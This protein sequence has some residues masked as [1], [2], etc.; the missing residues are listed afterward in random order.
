MSALRALLSCRAWVWNGLLLFLS[1]SLWPTHSHGQPRPIE[2]IGCSLTFAQFESAGETVRVRYSQMEIFLTAATMF[3]VGAI[4]P[5]NCTTAAPSGTSTTPAVFG[6]FPY[7]PSSSIC[8]AAIHAGII[9]NSAGGSLYVSRFYR[10]DWS[11]T[12]N[13]T[14]Y[15]FEAWRGSLSNGVQSGDVDGSSYRVPAGSREWSYTVRGR[16]DFVSQRRVAPFAPRAG[17]VHELFWQDGNQANSTVST[18]FAVHVIIG[19]NNDTAYFND[20]WVATARLDEAGEDMTWY[21]LEEAPLSPRSD[22]LVV[23]TAPRNLAPPALFL[24]GGQVS[25]AC[26]LYEL[27]V[28]SSEVWQLDV[29]IDVVTGAPSARWSQQTSLS[30]SMASRC[31]SGMAAD[32]YFQQRSVNLTLV[33]GQLSYNDSSCSSLPITVSEQWALNLTS[34][35]VTRL[36]DAPF[37]PR[38]WGSGSGTGR[39]LI[40]G[41]RHLNISRASSGQARL[42]AS[43][44]NADGW[45]CYQYGLSD[46]NVPAAW[47]GSSMVVWN[48]SLNGTVV[49]PLSVPLP[50]AAAAVVKST[51]YLASNSLAFGGVIP[52][53]AIEQWRLTRPVVDDE[54]DDVEWG[55]VAVNATLVTE[56]TVDARSAA[57]VMA[58]RMNLPLTAVMDE[59]EL[60]DPDGNYV[61]GVGWAVG[62][63]W[64][65]STSTVNSGAVSLHERPRAFSDSPASSSW[66]TPMAASSAATRRPLLNFDLRRR[67]HVAA[68]VV[69]LVTVGV[70][71]NWHGAY[72]AHQWTSGGRSGS[73]YYN[74]V[75]LQLPMELLPPTDPSYRAALG[76]VEL[77]QGVRPGVVVRCPAQYHFEPPT[78]DIYATLSLMADSMYHDWEA[79]TVRRCVPDVLN[80]TAPLVDLGLE[81]CQPQLP[82]V[83]DVYLSYPFNGGIKRLE[84]GGVAVTGVP[85]N[86]E[87]GAVTLTLR[88]SLFVEPVRVTVQGQ[89]CLHVTLSE[90]VQVCYNAS[91]SLDRSQ[92]WLVCD[93]M[94]REVT[95]E[96]PRLVGVAMDVIV[97]SGRGAEH[98]ETNSERTDSLIV[99]LTSAAPAVTR[100]E[101]ADCQADSPLGLLH[102]PVTRVFNL[103]VC[104]A[105]DSI[106]WNSTLQMMLGGRATGN[107]STYIDRGAAEFCA[108]CTVLP[109][110]GSQL[111]LVLVQ[112]FGLQSVTSATLSFDGCPAGTMLSTTALLT[113]AANLCSACPAGSSTMSSS[114]EMQCTLCQA[115]TYSNAGDE[116]C[117]PCPAGRYSASSNQSSCSPCP[118]NSYAND[119]RQ[120]GCQLCSLNDY[121]VY[122]HNH[123]HARPVDGECVACPVGS[124]C[125]ISGNILAAAG[126]YLL[127]DQHAAT[128]SAIRC[129][130]TACM[131]AATQC[132]A[133]GDSDGGGGSGQ[134]QQQ[135]QLIAASQL[136]VL[137]CCGPGRWPAHVNI[138]SF[139]PLDINFTSALSLPDAI[140]DTDGVNVLCAHCLPG[141]SAINGR[142]VECPSVQW[143]A[144]SGVLLLAVLLVYAV[145]RLPHDWTGSATLSIVAYFVQLS[146][147]YKASD[148]LPQLFALVNFQLLGGY[149]ASS[150][151]STAAD[152]DDGGSALAMCVMPLDD[153]DHIRLSFLSP[154]LA[155]S[156]LGAV[157][158]VQV[159]VRAAI[160]C[161]SGGDDDSD[162]G[163]VGG[164]SSHCC[165]RSAAWRVYEWLFVPAQPRTHPSSAEQGAVSGP[166]S[167]IEERSEPLMADS[168][169]SQSQQQQE[170][171][172]VKPPA[173]RFVWRSYQRSMVRLVLLSYSGLSLVA[174]SC[175]HWQAVSEYGYRLTDYTTVAHGSSE[176]STLLPGV[177]LVLIVVCCAPVALLLF[178]WHQHRGGHIADA[179]RK[180]QEL[181]ADASELAVREQLVLQLTAMYR[182]QHWWMPAYVLVRRLLAAVLLVTVRQS[183][184][185]VWLTVTSFIQLVIHLR[186]Q[187]YERAV[188]NEF[189]SLTLLSLS[190]Q[191]ALLAAYP[192]PIPSSVSG[193]LVGTTTALIAAPLLAIAIHVI[194]R[195]YRQH[196]EVRY[197]RHQPQPDG[198]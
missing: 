91:V 31:G 170:R 11:N 85:P 146:A 131:S 193:A 109:Q 39:V 118:L 168:Q 66:W 65:A 57:D 181:G 175:L 59:Q 22:V 86:Y 119:T 55:E 148:L 60:N 69:H 126:Q 107:C 83:E 187:P 114:G 21:R 150:Q 81:Y 89:D 196:R 36:A 122:S 54:L 23:R 7:S 178:L 71:P 163:N 156:L 43:E 5:A 35:V 145:H 192:P 127:I 136:R 141:H 100:L 44:V 98:A 143:G 180:L 84:D 47:N 113:G 12:T 6:S 45:V 51:L 108:H 112:S 2:L 121:I 61:R 17:H 106:A 73:L 144:L 29:V 172:A 165:S 3:N 111:P 140:L 166:Q 46:C 152:A 105:S 77:V 15:P 149:T 188:D 97:I 174:L 82:V 197:Q 74:D 117:S 38:R 138:S 33:A 182:T 13:Q 50:T 95:C 179:K 133:A 99:S 162:S 125:T 1:L 32:D 171:S 88:G 142:C 147:M 26:G 79:R 198:L 25:H 167:L 185:W 72:V 130:S 158:V 115:G 20:V 92:P 30:S 102:C 9:A 116:D 90:P 10:H 41:I 62:Y 110:Y 173:A 93:A 177:V 137:N 134:Q 155:F 123:S 49:P 70:P 27:G 186:L 132:P 153:V 164:S 124:M 16:G 169:H 183:S 80:C 94:S 161:W 194:A 14:I 96:L 8:L 104:A 129:S 67:D 189:E 64:Q 87:G 160:I 19:G 63:A 78:A 37:S 76:P 68:D 151:P 28:C 42:S 139:L 128:V 53:A 24:I 190:L 34:W 184:V 18:L 52:A 120:T 154:V 75:M 103:T 40:G 176:W 56:K 159:A 58:G 135:P 157:A 195:A 101:S 4:C 191:T 48:G